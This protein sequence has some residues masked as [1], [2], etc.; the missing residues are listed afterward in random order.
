MDDDP[1]K[2]FQ[3]NAYLLAR[4]ESARKVRNKIYEKT[5][6]ELEVPFVEELI[7]YV[8][9]AAIEGLKMQ[10]Q[11]FTIHVDKGVINEPE[12]PEGNDDDETKH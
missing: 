12:E 3:I 10:N 1:R 8:A 2:Y 7:E 6:L 11:I 4:K 9:M 5:G